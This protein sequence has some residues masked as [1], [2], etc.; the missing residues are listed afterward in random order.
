MN[1]VWLV[2]RS[3]RPDP[4]YMASGGRSSALRERVASGE[5]AVD[6]HAVAEAMLS[7]M[8]VAA[9]PLGRHPLGTGQD[10]A[11]TPLDGSEP[12]HG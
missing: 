9:Q 7:R 10:D 4:G 2:R 3:E 6:P 11:G 5:Y 12:G 8:L 1:R